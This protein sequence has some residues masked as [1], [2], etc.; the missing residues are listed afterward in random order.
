M[1]LSLENIDFVIA[2]T[3]SFPIRLL[4]ILAESEHSGLPGYVSILA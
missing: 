2:V 4:W 3:K 1:T